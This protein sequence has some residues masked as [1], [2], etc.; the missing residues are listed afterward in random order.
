MTIVSRW[1]SSSI[2]WVSFSSVSSF[3]LSCPPH[4]ELPEQ[5]CRTGMAL[6]ASPI[7]I[8]RWRLFDQLKKKIIVLVPLGCIWFVNPVFSFFR[9]D[10]N[11]GSNV[12]CRKGDSNSMRL[13]WLEIKRPH[14][15][16]LM[17]IAF[18]YDRLL[19]LFRRRW[20]RRSILD[21]QILHAF[22]AV[23]TAVA[24]IGHILFVFTLRPHFDR[25][26]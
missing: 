26:W 9:W 18:S 11:V 12:L 20:H 24:G 4:G 19:L 17:A 1:A 5:D 14:D 22:Y 21:L 25:R 16:M 3:H 7:R 13:T 6:R 8:G 10:V 15:K 23:V 2:N